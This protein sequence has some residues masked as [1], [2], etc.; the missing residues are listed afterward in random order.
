MTEERET[1]TKV[2]D[3]ETSTKNAQENQGD[4]RKKTNPP[5][6]YVC[7]CCNIAGHWIQQCPQKKKHSKNSDTLTLQL[8]KLMVKYLAQTRKL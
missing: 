1:K 2:D 4:G 8:S 5:D 6:G 7:N 3:E